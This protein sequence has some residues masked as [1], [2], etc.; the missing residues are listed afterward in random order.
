MRFPDFYGNELLKQRLSRMLLHNSFGHCF[1][2]CGPQGSGKHT[3]ARI[4]AS[5]LQCTASSDRP[6]GSCVHCRKSANGAHPDIIWIDSDKATVPV[7]LIRSMRADAFVQPNEGNRKIYIIPRAQ[8]MQ[9]AAQNALLKILEEPPSYCTF[10][11]LT[12]SPDKLLTTVRSRAVELTLCPLSD[13]DLRFA[14][15]KL[16]PQADEQAITFAGEHSDGYLGAALTLIDNGDYQQ[17]PRLLE[18]ISAF[19]SGDELTILNTLVPMEKL[20]RRSLLAF[21]SEFY[22]TAIKAL[23]TGQTNGAALAEVRQLSTLPSDRLF[24]LIRDLKQVISLLQANGNTGGCVGL[25][26]T[27]LTT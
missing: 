9:D 20:D 4:M 8:D 6:C 23:R 26:L 19:A 7:D 12:D 21:V 17:D 13:N 27:C 15:K 25:L 1:L 14:L 11:L 16:R 22:E 18:L 2:L 10:L 3:L 5:A 24:Q